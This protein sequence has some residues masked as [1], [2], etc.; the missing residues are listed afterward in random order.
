[1]PR[2]ITVPRLSDA[3]DEGMLVAWFVEPGQRVS[4]GDTVAEVQM[5]KTSYDVVAPAAGR[6]ERL[7]AA[8]GDIVTA[9]TAIAT[10]ADDGGDGVSA[11]TP[12]Q[13]TSAAVPAET[14]P[15]PAEVAAVPGET[16]PTAA[17]ALA[18][19]P[20]GLPAPGDGGDGDE[21]RVAASPA[22][23]RLARELGVELRRV[24]GSGPGG[25]IQESDVRAVA[26][27]G[28]AVA[29]PAAQ[30]AQASPA[31][32]TPVREPGLVPISIMR[33]TIADRLRTGL[34]ETAQLTLTA[35]ADVTDL[36]ARLGAWTARLGRKVGY[37]EALVRACAAALGEHPRLA[38]AWTD[39]GLV[40]A[41][42]IDVGV[43]VALPDGLLVPVVRGADRKDL[44]ELGTEIAGLADRARSGVLTAAETSGACFT[45]TS[46]GAWR[47]DAFTPLLDPPQTAIMGIGRARLRPAV[48]DGAIV[49]RMLLVLSL[50][51]DH[52]VVDGAPAAA[53]LEAVVCRL[54]TP[55][56]MEAPGLPGA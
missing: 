16:G 41:R 21:V 3:T 54:E 2:D 42:S 28:P 39:R 15:A 6:I 7:L 40:P 1:M 50:T 12:A 30:A 5:E 26:E 19:S 34:A 51:I 49:P 38:M 31:A 24:A 25:R 20:A 52:R 36:A 53:F 22:A 23:R 17:P 46:L 10:L 9:A 11:T 13:T 47:I 14:A 45:V 44:S 27:A 18:A 37:T 48:V 32:P 4:A 43:A 56:W 33:R 55:G 29:P 8:P 35:E